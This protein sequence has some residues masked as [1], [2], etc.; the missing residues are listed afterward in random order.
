MLGS[1]NICALPETETETIP[2]IDDLDKTVKNYST[3]TLS[4]ADC[5]NMSISTFLNQ[6][7]NINASIAQFTPKQQNTNCYYASKHVIKN[8][9]KVAK[10]NLLC[11]ISTAFRDIL[12]SIIIWSTYLS[13]QIIEFRNFLVNFPK[14]SCIVVHKRSAAKEN[15]NNMSNMFIRHK[16]QNDPYNL[17]AETAYMNFEFNRRLKQIAIKTFESI[18]FTFFIG[19][20]CVPVNVNIRESEYFVYFLTASLNTLISYWLYYIP[21]SFLSK[22]Y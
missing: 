22:I 4:Y 1:E 2:V 9:S 11:K 5:S 6:N 19:R 18:Y 21:L 16:C 10:T 8:R 12:Q 13:K 14:T 3:S 20:I 15:N 17:R 7:V